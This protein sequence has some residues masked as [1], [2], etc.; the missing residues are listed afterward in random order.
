MPGSSSFR[1]LAKART[2][3][4]GTW[5]LPEGPG[6]PSW[7]LRTRSHRGPVEVRTYQC[8]PGSLIFP[9]H[10]VLLTL[11]YVVGLGAAPRVT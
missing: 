8:I 9:C 11:P 7:E 1:D 10:M 6:M 5:G 2:L 3:L 4:G